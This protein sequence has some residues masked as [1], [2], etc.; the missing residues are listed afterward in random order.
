MWAARD[1]LRLH[2]KSGSAGLKHVVVL[3]QQAKSA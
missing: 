1:E 3:L 2:I